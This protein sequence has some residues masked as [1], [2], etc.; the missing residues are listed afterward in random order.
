MDDLIAF[1]RARLDEDEQAATAAA[2]SNIERLS[3]Q[4]HLAGQTW[5]ADGGLVMAG[6]QGLWDCEGSDTLCM[7]EPC[8][9]HIARHDPGRVLAEVDAKRRIVDL[10]SP[11]EV[12][13]MDHETWGQTF[14]VCRSCREGD[15]QIVAP[16]PTLRLLALPAAD[17]PDYREEWRP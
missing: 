12:A 10:H 16:C 1:L 3:A 4:P 8:A 11:R 5:T 2:E 9:E 15:R 6:S 17:H 13:S 14:Q 7:T